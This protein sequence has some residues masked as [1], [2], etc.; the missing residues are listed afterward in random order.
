M[1]NPFLTKGSF[2]VKEA[3]AKV[4][5]NL[6]NDV[7]MFYR[8]SRTGFDMRP[9]EGQ[10]SGLSFEMCHN[11]SKLR[12]YFA[13]SLFVGQM[14]PEDSSTLVSY[15][16][17]PRKIFVALFVSSLVMSLLFLFKWFVSDSSFFLALLMPIHSAS[18]AYTFHKGRSSAL[19]QLQASCLKN[20]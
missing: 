4:A 19:K 20:E 5:E 9:F 18:L 7:E 1:S 2:V 16:Q 3:P 13:E 10:V 11:N 8:N 17:Q 12:R 6:S 15:T 14:L